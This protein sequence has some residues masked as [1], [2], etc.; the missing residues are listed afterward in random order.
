M[1]VFIIQ[2]TYIHKC[3][4]LYR[5]LLNIVS[6]LEAAAGLNSS[7]RINVWQDSLWFHVLLNSNSKR[8]GLL[9]KTFPFTDQSQ[10]RSHA[11]WRRDSVSWSLIG[12]WSCLDVARSRT[13]HPICS[14]IVGLNYIKASNQILFSERPCLISAWTNKSV[15]TNSDFNRP[16]SRKP[17]SNPT[18]NR[19][20]TVNKKRAWTESPCHKTITTDDKRSRCF[21]K[22]HHIFICSWMLVSQPV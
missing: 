17:N 13:T 19:T 22:T 14:R 6:L 18:G 5:I 12:Q 16:K 15:G 4:T 10:F 11:K 8:C 3:M 9:C 7:G 21:I 1:L 2:I 20:K